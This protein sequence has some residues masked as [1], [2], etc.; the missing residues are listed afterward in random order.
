MEPLDPGNLL[1]RE[2]GELSKPLKVRHVTL[3]EPVESRNVNQVI[4]AMNLV[5]AKMHFLGVVVNRIHSDRAKEL[6]SHKFQ[7]W[8]NQRNI[9]HSFTAG[10]DPQSNGHCEAEVCQLKRRTR[11]LLHVASQE[12]TSWPQAM[13]Y[14]TEERLRTQLEALGT[15]TPKMIPYHSKVLVKRKRWHE[16]GNHLAQPFVEARVLCPSP[17]MTSGWMVESAKDKQVLHAREAILPDPVGD[18][19]QLQL[20][21]QEANTKPPFRFVGKQP[22]PVKPPFKISWPRSD[23]GGEPLEPDLENLRFEEK[24]D[25]NE[26]KHELFGEGDLQEFEELFG[27]ETGNDG[28]RAVKAMCCGEGTGSVVKTERLEVLEQGMNCMHTN[29][30]TNLKSLLDVVPTTR[31]LG[32]LCGWEMQWITKQREWLEHDLATIRELQNRQTVRLCGLQVTEESMQGQGEVLQ[33]TTV[34]LSEVRRELPEWKNA[35]MNE[36]RSLV[37]ETRAIEP[38]ELSSL[39][40][41]N[42]EFVPGKLVTV[43]KAGPQGGKKKC[44]AVVCGNLLQNDLDPAPGGLYASGADGVLI[45]ATLAHSVQKGWGIGTTDIRTA[46]LLAP[47]P[48]DQSLWFLPKLWWKPGCAHLLSDGGCT[49]LFTG[50]I[51]ALHTGQ[52][53]V[54]K[55]CQH[56]GGFRVMKTFV[57][58][59]LRKG[60]F[61]KS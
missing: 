16:Q 47:R 54:T 32:E 24:E 17:H 11:L 10:N 20:E 21:E 2:V 34:P 5:L 4:S 1:E 36:Y 29:A 18:L 13:R 42:V 14:A 39:D 59:R 30:V 55:P 19:A 23:R 48:R 27:E 52:F 22:M 58:K 56:L 50:S 31:S 61:G 33:T 49:T 44:R 43:G 6:L 37:H 53:I 15:P 45:R 41:E 46:F 40:S 57:W 28:K 8:V 26:K 60:V 9:L 12:N 7:S 25:E 51:P 38:V 35:M 3:M